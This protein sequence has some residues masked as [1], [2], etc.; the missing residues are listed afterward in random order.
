MKKKLHKTQALRWKKNRKNTVYFP[1]LWVNLLNLT[2]SRV[3]FWDGDVCREE[4]KLK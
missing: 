1:A 4:K 3:G 2:L